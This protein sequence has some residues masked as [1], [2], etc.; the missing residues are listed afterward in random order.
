MGSML[1][2]TEGQPVG[3][4]ALLLGCGTGEL[5]SG[6]QVWQQAHLLAESSN[7]SLMFLNVPLDCLVYLKRTRVT[8]IIEVPYHIKSV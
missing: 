4:S 5:N 6:S 3:V 2:V 8:S 7:E 1:V